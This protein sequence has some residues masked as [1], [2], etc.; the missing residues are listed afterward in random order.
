[1]LTIKACTRYSI[2]D[3]LRQ[4]F[5]SVYHYHLARAVSTPVVTDNRNLTEL[6]AAF[7]RVLKCGLADLPEHGYD[8]EDVGRPGSPEEDLITL[9][10]HDP[11]AVDFRNCIRT[12]FGKAPWSSI[13]REEM[14]AWLHWAIFN[15]RFHSFEALPPARQQVLREALD[16]IEKRAGAA[17]P[18]GSNPDVRAFQLTSDPVFIAWR[19]FIWYLGVA[20]SNQYHR[21]QF[22]SR[23]N[24]TV[25]TFQDLE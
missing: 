6:Q 10:R 2:F 12:W 18:H 8:E 15:T 23:W 3:A 21:R 20:L 22:K 9:E 25:A 1:M 14:F 19:P 7:R 24:V 4:V 17:I 5:F 16:M 11:R 13:H